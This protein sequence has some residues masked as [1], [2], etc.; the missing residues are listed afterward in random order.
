MR[1][2][3]CLV[4][5]VLAMA[6]GCASSPVKRVE[7]VSLDAADA[8]RR[9]GCYDCLIEA[10]DAYRRAAVG[11]TRPVAL[12]RWFETELLI[13]LR[14]TEL[15]L[16]SSV[17]LASARAIVPELP[18][19]IGADRYLYDVMQVPHEGA[20][21]PRSE[22]A[23]FRKEHL[24]FVGSVDTELAWIHAGTIDPMVREYIA[25]AIDCSYR[26]R[27]RPAGQAAAPVK[28]EPAPDVAPLIRYRLATCGR[29]HTPL[30]EGVRAEVPRFVETSYFVGLVLVA[31][32]G[33]GSTL[34]PHELAAETQKRFPQSPA[35]MYLGGALKQAVG[36]CEQAVGLFEQTIGLRPR[37]EDAWLGRT[38][39]FTELQRPDDAIAVA[40]R[41]IELGLDNQDQALYWRAWNHHAKGGLALARTDIDAARLR[42]ISGE[43][44]TLAGV[45][46]HDQDDLNPAQRDLERAVAI[47]QGGNCR[48]LWFLGSVFVKRESWRDAAPAFDRAMTCLEQDVLARENMLE[49]LEKR[50]GVD[51]E[52]KRRQGTKLREQIAA[53]RHQQFS[54]AFNA[55]NFHYASGNLDRAKVLIEV[56]ANAPELSAEVDSLRK[57]MADLTAS[58][59]AAGP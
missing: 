9:Q 29:I 19:A 44:L 58:R 8:S 24:P 54:A 5:A 13:A 28:P 38:I 52:Y 20:G 2:R 40:T 7:P 42:R 23:A 15:A 31:T 22:G 48:A 32:I 36:D 43:I 47:S 59:R 56:A 34:N 50:V 17:A 12:Q 45:I 27:P 33:Q 55:A 39:C 21:W 6:S 26:S 37:H 49:S 14:E 35:V 16:D 10:R 30:L 4:L 51:A 1:S 46:E 53:Q 18:P 41:M 57:A 11:P 3:L 25:T